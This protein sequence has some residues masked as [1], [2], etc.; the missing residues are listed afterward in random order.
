MMGGSGFVVRDL[1]AS[2]RLAQWAMRW[3]ASTAHMKH[4]QLLPR[5]VAFIKACYQ[6]PSELTASSGPRR[7]RPPLFAPFAALAFLKKA[8]VHGNRQGILKH[9]PFPPRVLI[10]LNFDLVP[11]FPIF[12]QQPVD[13]GV[14]PLA[15]HGSLQTTKIDANRS[16]VFC[17]VFEKKN[18]A[19]KVL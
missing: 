12:R 4:H 13:P 10:H 17:G 5:A 11:G 16:A 8:E 14:G 2:L 6:G 9:A 18:C 15:P 3:R 7:T 19:L 1:S